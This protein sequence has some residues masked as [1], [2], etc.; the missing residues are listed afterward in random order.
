MALSQ[1]KR[2]KLSSFLGALPEAPATR[3]FAAIEAD[4]AQGGR[5]LPH[6]E[7]LASLRARLLD[8]GNALP[9]RAPTAQ[10][11]FFTPV[12]DFFIVKR[13]GPK[14]RAAIARESLRPIWALMQSIDELAQPIAALEATVSNGA[15]AQSAFDLWRAAGPVFDQIA[16]KA[17]ESS[18]H[19]AHYEAT[20]GGEDALGDLYELALLAPGVDYLSRMQTL[21]LHGAPSLTEE[22]LYKLRGV[23]LEAYEDAPVVG[24]YVLLALKGRLEKPWRALDVYYHF[25]KGADARMIAAKDAVTMLA[26]SLFED[27][28]SMARAMSRASER[29]LSPD[30]TMVRMRYF[31]EYAEGLA[32]I[33]AKTGDNVFLNRIEASRDIGADA[34][35]R[36][37]EQALSA[38]RAAT[39]VRHAGGASRLAAMRP[40]ISV[41]LSDAAADAAL[42]GAELLAQAPDL[43]DRLGARDRAAAT[44]VDDARDRLRVYASDLVMEI[45][46]A[47]GPSQKTAQ[48]LLGQVLRAAA[49]L[50][51]DDE[52]ALIRDRAAA[53]A[54]AV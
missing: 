54:V 3:L 50:L 47:E 40:D 27:L 52:I 25:A 39:P 45:R 29:S 28:E 48:S 23:F 22:Q 43:S 4:R 51:P 30:A 17:R 35:E 14:K 20:L 53:A 36:F 6:D 34:F 8:R 9:E 15:A 24:E 26:E 2:E 37:C 42:K 33:A 32:R 12:E 21:I 41:R 13:T 11:I 7:I 44:L 46:A 10:R 38:V 31:S 16:D 49:P 18:V 19:K 5:D 1:D